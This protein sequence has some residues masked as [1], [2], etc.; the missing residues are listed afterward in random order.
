MAD[1]YSDGARNFHFEGYY[2]PVSLRAESA[3][4]RVQGRSL[5]NGLEAE[6]VCRHTLCL[7]KVP[8]FELL[9]TLSNLN[10]FS[11]FLHCRKR[12]KFATKRI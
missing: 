10:R 12:I 6:A 5:G 4:S 8:T 2:S 7:K 1:S 9:V 11:K 3:P